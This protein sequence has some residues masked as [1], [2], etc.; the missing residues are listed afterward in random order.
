MVGKGVGRLI[1]PYYGGV[2]LPREAVG[3]LEKRGFRVNAF[4]PFKPSSTIYL[5]KSAEMRAWFH[6]QREEEYKEMSSADVGFIFSPTTYQQIPMPGEREPQ[7]HRATHYPSRKVLE[8]YFNCPC[9]PAVREN[10]GKKMWEKAKV[11]G[12]MGLSYIKAAVIRYMLTEEVERA[13][14]ILA[15][16]SLFKR[17][18][19]I[20]MSEEVAKWSSWIATKW[21]HVT[22]ETALEVLER[23]LEENET[24]Y[25]NVIHGQKALTAFAVDKEVAE[26][27]FEKFHWRAEKELREIEAF[28]RMVE[29]AKG[30][31]E[32]PNALPTLL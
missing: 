31:K 2:V 25:L 11:V 8:A 20:V 10:F 18:S 12:A 6:K 15:E 14:E 4:E 22:D 9:S 1:L 24:F 7:I 28:N 26:E 23:E 30:V 32:D 17:L 21:V 13:V 29:K 19:K 27:A 3:E 16:S 5:V